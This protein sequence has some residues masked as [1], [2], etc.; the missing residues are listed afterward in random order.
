MSE[1]TI[2]PRPLLYF[3]DATRKYDAEL[4]ERSGGKIFD[5][6]LFDMNLHVSCC[7]T[8]PSY[9]ME[10]IDAVPLVWPEDDKKRAELSEDLHGANIHEDRLCYFEV[11]GWLG[12]ATREGAE[13]PDSWDW[14]TAPALMQV[15]KPDPTD[16]ETW[17]RYLEENDGNVRSAHAFFIEDTLEDINGNAR[18]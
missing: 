1:G 17:E 12:A 8:T 10:I 4:V 14:V 6:Y 18:Y 13:I 9:E 7:S 5:V 3:T 2:T 15:N 11:T 16:V